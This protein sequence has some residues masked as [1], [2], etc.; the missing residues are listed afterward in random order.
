M[1]IKNLFCPSWVLI[2]VFLFAANA[3]GQQTELGNVDFPTSGSAKAQTHFLRGVAALHSFWY[4]E[5]LDEFQEATKIEPDFMMGYWGEAMAYN[6]TLWWQQ[7]TAAARSV[8]TNIKDSGKLTERERAYLNAVRVLYGEGEKQARDVAYSLAM[9]KIYR[10]YPDDLE[11]AAFYSLSILGALRRGE[12]GFGRQMKAGAIAMDV[13]Q[14]NSNHPGAAHY[15][16]H[17]FDDP[18]HAILALPA[19]YRYAQIAPAS[20]H[21][22]HMPSHI[23]IQL[24][25][26]DRVVSSNESAW[27]V[28][29]SWV[30]NKKLSPRLRDY[31]SL[32]WLLYG[33]VQQG[34]Y[35]K[36]A[37]TIE[38]IKKTMAPAG[39]ENAGD[40]DF[41][42]TYYEMMTAQFIVNSERWNEAV[43]LFDAMPKT[44]TMKAASQPAQSGE[45]A[46][47]SLK[48]APTDAK[49]V[50]PAAEADDDYVIFVKGLS[51]ALMNN[52]KVALQNAEKLR[53]MREPG[54]GTSEIMGLE[55]KAAAASMA[56]N[57]DEAIKLMKQA[58]AIEDDMPP[59]SGPP[60]LI[61][62]SHELFGEIL[63]RAGRFKEASQAFANS[64][65]RHP[66][67]IRSLLGAARTAQKL[68]DRKQ[69][70]EAYSMFLKIQSQAD[71]G[72]IA[73]REAQ[74][75]LKQTNQLSAN[76]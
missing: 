9:E 51:A 53:M 6:H 46:A 16:I 21:A 43:K 15:I 52:Q 30:K 23:F 7:N 54:D 2:F 5:A 17:A 71:A 29:E 69:A 28:S 60:Q 59:P 11:A 70:V 66:N 50:Y 49:A 74:D 36:A 56:G 73:V 39:M 10:D 72:S 25:M 22:R 19:A 68:G 27:A 34:R 12:K 55:I 35:N 42:E 48:T 20:S 24:G 26:W 38:V 58:T 13:Y 37:E 61:K 33:Y 18:E 32:S 31:H 45:H 62:P 57:H 67:R 1:F 4:K 64:L 75:F 41:Y 47:H 8:L 44:S 63:L 3:G 14:K 76:R 40:S 65:A